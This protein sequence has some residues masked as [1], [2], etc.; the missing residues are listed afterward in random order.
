MLVLFFLTSFA[1][2]YDNNWIFGLGENYIFSFENEL[3]QVSNINSP[4][5]SIFSF[6]S[7]SNAEGKLLFYTNGNIILNNENLIMVNGDSINYGRFWNLNDHKGYSDPTG[8]IIL[9]S[10]DDRTKY[11]VIYKRLEYDSD[12][13]GVVHSDRFQ[14]SIVD[15]TKENGL[16]SVIKKDQL[17]LQDTFD[18]GNITACR[19]ANGRDWWLINRKYNSNSFLKFLLDPSGINIADTTIVGNKSLN[20]LGQ[21]VFTPNGRKY[22]DYNGHDAEK[23][24]FLDIYDFDRCTGELSNPIQFNYL[25][26]T[27]WSGGVAVSSNSRFLYLSNTLRLYQF[28][29]W[30]DD[31]IGS[32]DTIAEYES[33][34]SFPFFSHFYL[35]H[36]APDG[37][38]YMSSKNGVSSLHVIHEPNKK[39]KACNFVQSGLQL[40]RTIGFGMPNFPNFRL[41]DVP[42]S[43]CDTLGINDPVSSSHELSKNYQLKIYPNPATDIINIEIKNP[44]INGQIV[45][46]DLT[47]RTLKKWAFEN[48]LKKEIEVSKVPKG[49]Y[50]LSVR[51]EGVLLSTQKIII[52]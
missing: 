33:I 28:D 36:L 34:D 22:I 31:I 5:E 49:L 30:A 26:T 50:F 23:G 27:V 14:Y 9:P 42:D 46:T 19:H 18:N 16:G 51:N 37:K 17:I 12:L 44:L 21:S 45:L 38:I 29:L 43:P 3:L 4:I 8:Y 52:Q 2:K 47:G 40:D 15:M 6:F 35:P 32:I 41:Y 7:I 39:G 25:D 24:M 11:Y 48:Q 13:E 20:G 1:Q 10:P